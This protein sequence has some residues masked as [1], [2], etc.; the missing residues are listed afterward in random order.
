[1]RFNYQFGPMKLMCNS[2]KLPFTNFLAIK[3]FI[4]T[5]IVESSQRE[6]TKKR[7]VLRKGVDKHPKLCFCGKETRKPS[8]Y[9]LCIRKINRTQ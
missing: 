9:T 1:M 7:N 8:I 4:K 5:R 3:I 2:R 6:D